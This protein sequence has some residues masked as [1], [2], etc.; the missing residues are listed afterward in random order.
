MDT[1]TERDRLTC[2]VI[3]HRGASAA[4][5][6]NTLAAFA[7]AAD[8]GADWVELDV[9]RSA[10]GVA[11]VHHD[12]VL[13]DGRAVTAVAVADL[14]PSVPTLAAALATCRAHGLGVNVEIKSDPRQ[15]DFDAGYAVVDV[16]LTAMAL[17]E[18]GGDIA[19][20][21]GSARFLVTS[22]DPG[23]LAAVRAR[24]GHATGQLGFDIRDTAAMIAAAAA[25]GHVAVYPW[26]PVVD[27]AFVAAAH[28]AGLRVFPWTVD[29]PTRMA[30]L[31]DL[32][33]DGIITNVPDVL[34]S[35][36]G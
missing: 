4:H 24:S 27:E 5:P 21:D 15:P 19:L 31:V 3:G 18:A 17:D 11:V 8:L 23:C 28:D 34:R 22:F 16:A 14:P 12:A 26:E 30:V 32:G 1:T 6:E 35:I 7:G 9:H 13:P 10:D 33:V 36:V 20:A 25:A 2:L 29:D